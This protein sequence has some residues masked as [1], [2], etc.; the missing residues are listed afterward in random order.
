MTKIVSIPPRQVRWA[1]KQADARNEFYEN[2]TKYNDERD[3]D[4]VDDNFVGL[5]GEL[6]FAIYYDL[7][8]D[9]E[10]HDISDGGDDFDVALGGEELSVDIKGRRKRPD[11]FW[12]KEK[13][14]TADY[15]VLAHVVQP[16]DNS[17]N[18]G[19]EVELIGGTSNATF[20]DATRVRSDL[21]F[22]NRSIFVGDL[23]TLPEPGSVTSS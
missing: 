20:Q 10:I 15:F 5:L 3:G 2:E 6:G 19:W 18:E 1:R 8:V 16:D 7:Q 13:S 21:G 4:P 23:D 14:L 12:V 11:R 22:W 9:A 17:L